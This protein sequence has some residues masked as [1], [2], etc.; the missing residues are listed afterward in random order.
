MKGEGR[1]TTHLKIDWPHA[2]AERLCQADREIG[3]LLR[4]S[5]TRVTD[6]REREKW[7]SEALIPLRQI[8]RSL[9]VPAGCEFRV[10]SNLDHACGLAGFRDAPESFEKPFLMIDQKGF[11]LCDSEQLELYYSGLVVHECGHLRHTRLGYARKQRYQTKLLKVIDNFLEDARIESLLRDEAP[12]FAPGLHALRCIVDYPVAMDYRALFPTLPDI[13][14]VH[15]LI[16]TMIQCPHLATDEMRFWKCLDGTVVWDRLLGIMQ[17]APTTDDDVERITVNLVACIAEIRSQ[18]PLATNYVDVFGGEE[19]DKSTAAIRQ[20]EADIEDTVMQEGASPEIRWALMELACCQLQTQES[21]LLTDA[22]NRIRNLAGRMAEGETAEQLDQGR[23]FRLDGLDDHLKGKSSHVVVPFSMESANRLHGMLNSGDEE[24]DQQVTL[25]G[26][27]W[28]WEKERETC[29]QVAAV[30]PEI[31]VRYAQL[32]DA[33]QR[34]AA[35]L[36]SVFQLRLKSNAPAIIREQISGKIDSRRLAHASFSERIFRRSVEK[37][38]PPKLAFG[39]LLDESGSMLQDDRSQAAAEVA[40]MLA[41]AIRGLP[42]IQ[43]E[44]YSHTSCGEEDWNCRIRHLYGRSQRQPQAIATYPEL[45]SANYDHQALL[46][47]ADMLRKSTSQ[48]EY[49]CLLVVSDGLPNGRH[50]G[51]APAVNATRE[52]VDTVRMS[53]I[54]VVGIAIQ[55]FAAAEIYGTDHTLQFTSLADLT[56]EFRRLLTRT[57]RSRRS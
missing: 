2:E 36:R 23:R 4:R 12:G 38:G 46:T 16:F 44:V 5:G 29:I 47:V 57:I 6:P 10:A 20:I 42:D 22:A 8:T 37:P 19:S 31:A 52:A 43:L 28:H 39:L 18:Y 17:L 1:M 15:L 27:S 50:Y 3:A 51:G 9:H 25:A 54:Q 13:D 48:A 53:G 55:S 56:H 49:R 26:P 32:R 30:D 11:E 7:M 35:A 33:V 40:V 45:P 24:S 34:E 41:E 14:R 21:P